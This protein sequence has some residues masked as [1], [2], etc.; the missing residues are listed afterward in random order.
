MTCTSIQKLCLKFKGIFCNFVVKFNMQI[1]LYLVP[2]PK[3][4][5]HRA[6]HN[7]SPPNRGDPFRIS[8]SNFSGKELRIIGLHYSENCNQLFSH[9]VTIHSR[10]DRRQTERQTTDRETDDRQLIRP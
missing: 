8:S 2:F 1:V 6:R 10:L 3:Y 7:L 4:S 5:M 9:F